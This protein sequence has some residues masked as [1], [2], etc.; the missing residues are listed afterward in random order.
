[1]T[2]FYKTLFTLLFTVLSVSISTAM[3]ST[4]E[5]LVHGKLTGEALEKTTLEF[6]DAMQS[7]HR[8]GLNN[9]QIYEKYLDKIGVNR[10][11]KYLHAEDKSCHGVAHDLGKVIGEKVSDLKTGMQICRDTCTYACLHGVFGVYF[12]KLGKNYD[13]DSHANHDMS[14]GHHG[15]HAMHAEAK[16]VELTGEELEKF[17]ES[18]NEACADSGAIVEDFFRGNCAHG[19]GHAMGKIAT[20]IKLSTEYCQLFDSATMQYYC[21]T[22]VFMELGG[23]VKMD[24]FEGK[25]ARSEKIAAALDYCGENSRHPSS[26]LRFL[27]PRNKSL[28]QITRYATLC[29]KREGR[30]RQHCFNAL[31]Y[32]SRTYIAKNPNEIEYTCVLA[33]GDD[34]TACISGITFMKK[35]QRYRNNIVEACSTL[36]DKND[37]KICNEQVNHF[38]YDV[39][40]KTMADII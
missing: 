6:A 25:T 26:C 5:Q 29:S 11:A 38:Y 7:K 34:R 33:K 8:T 35:G 23:Q 17:S 10:I 1:M 13:N 27:L 40:N 36:N 31:G 39:T 4:S 2:T 12:Y 19:V 24:L 3:A 21:E 15:H 22:G 9:Y 18:V 16:P 37:K 28:G 14:G 32:H 30:L 20:K